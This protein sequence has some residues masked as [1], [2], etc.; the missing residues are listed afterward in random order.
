MQHVEAMQYL[1][2][3]VLHTSVINNHSF[4]TKKNGGYCQN[5]VTLLEKYLWLIL[6]H[7]EKFYIR[8]YIYIMHSNTLSLVSPQYSVIALWFGTIKSK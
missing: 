6:I 3:L 2:N 8:A 7:E 5:I 4:V 1:N